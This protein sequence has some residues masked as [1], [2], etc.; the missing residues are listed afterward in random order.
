MKSF[1][2]ALVFGLMG[3]SWA[4]ASL[5]GNPGGPWDNLPT[6]VQEAFG[7]SPLRDYDPSRRINPFYLGGDL[8]ADGKPDYAILI[9]RKNDQKEGL[10]VF[11]NSYTKPHLLGAGIPSQ[12]WCK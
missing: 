10:V 7:S 2:Y 6:K 9:T 11:F 5:G 3:T 12:L 8:D 4:S 1:L